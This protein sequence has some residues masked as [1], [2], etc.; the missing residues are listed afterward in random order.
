MLLITYEMFF[1]K[2]VRGMN[3]HKNGFSTENIFSSVFV[4]FCVS[5]RQIV[6]V[7]FRQFS[8]VFVC[9]ALYF[10]LLKDTAR[11]VLLKLKENCWMLFQ[12]RLVQ[13]RL[14]FRTFSNFNKFQ[15]LP[16]PHWRVRVRWTQPGL[17][18]DASATRPNKTSKFRERK[19]WRE[20]TTEKSTR[21]D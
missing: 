17:R 15:F 20:A 21:N 7:F 14:S 5:L 4:S 8:S 6:S 18:H 12:I 13:F 9:L 10:S 3:A 2:G 19:R 1:R 11:I 16:V